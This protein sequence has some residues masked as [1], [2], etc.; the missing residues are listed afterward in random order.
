[1]H[2]VTGKLSLTQMD[3]RMQRLTHLVM[4]LL[5]DWYWLMQMPMVKQIYLLTQKERLTQM[6]LQKQ[7]L[8]LM[9]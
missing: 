4:Y 7:R 9:D 6:D 1:M 8:M 5:M 3:L 2:L